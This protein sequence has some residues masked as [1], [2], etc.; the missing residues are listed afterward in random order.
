MQPLSVVPAGAMIRMGSQNIPLVGKPILQG[1]R[2]AEDNSGFLG[3]LLVPLEASKK[4]W[5][6]WGGAVM[7]F[8]LASVGAPLLGQG[9]GKA[10]GMRLLESQVPGAFQTY[11]VFWKIPVPRSRKVSIAGL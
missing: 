11:L 7:A 4:L 9:P 3:S 2:P 5:G 10:A 8:L 6:A 1:A